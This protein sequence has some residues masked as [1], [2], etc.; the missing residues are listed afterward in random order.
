MVNTWPR[1]AKVIWS[2]FFLV[3]RPKK[4]DFAFFP[5][6]ADVCS[7]SKWLP[8]NTA[9]LL[10]QGAAV[11]ASC[12]PESRPNVHPTAPLP[13]L[14]VAACAPS[15]AQ[16]EAAVCAQGSARPMLT[17]PGAAHS[18]TPRPPG[19]R[20]PQLHTCPSLRARGC[21]CP[22]PTENTQSASRV[23]RKGWKQP[24]KNCLNWE[25]HNHLGVFEHLHIKDYEKIALRVCKAQHV[26]WEAKNLHL[27]HFRNATARHLLCSSSVCALHTGWKN[28]VVSHLS[29]KG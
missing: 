18:R 16:L 24:G 19:S 1:L 21:H 29:I 14:A 13:L 11:P 9:P 22:C 2:L 26:T 10:Q 12:A 15:T 6:F 23:V 17:P 3:W 8:P 28:S 4:I 20:T 7:W 5:P 25:S 27:L